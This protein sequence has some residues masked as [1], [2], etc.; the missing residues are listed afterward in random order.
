MTKAKQERCK[1]SLFFSRA[2]RKANSMKDFIA[3]SG[4]S[5]PSMER[6]G[7]SLSAVKSLVL[8]EKDDKLSSEFHSH[9][10]VFYLI[11]SLFSPGIRFLHG[12]L[13]I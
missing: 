11:N 5:L 6:T 12:L 3:S 1:L 13:L 8:R 2:G 7:L 10:K 4:G 9:K